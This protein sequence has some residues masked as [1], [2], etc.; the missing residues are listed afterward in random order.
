MQY[1]KN[2]IPQDLDCCAPLE[3]P[4]ETALGSIDFLM[5]DVNGSESAIQ[6]YYRLLN[7]GLRPALA[8]GTDFPCNFHQPIGTQLTYVRTADGRLSYRGWIEGIAAGRTVVSRNAHREFLDLQVNAKAGPG[9]EIALPAKGQVT[10]DVRWS[11]ATALEGRIEVVRN[12]VVVASRTSTAPAALHARVECKESSWIAA[13]RMD[14]KG[15]QLQTGAVY[16]IVNHAPVRASSADAD[17]FVRFIDNL[18]RQT[19][20]GG[21]WAGFFAQD[22]DAAQERYRRAKGMYERIAAEARA[23]GN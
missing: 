13:R 1:L 8:A 6:A 15:H 11:A 17:F 23:R 16:V 9:D 22:R 5:E 20:P 3:Y 14:A 19:S 18:I 21:A 2:D 4:V 10:V 12:G 7:C